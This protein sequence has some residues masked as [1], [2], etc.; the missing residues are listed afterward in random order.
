[1]IINP[2]KFY[3]KSVLF[4]YLVFLITSLS[5]RAADKIPGMNLY[6]TP[7][8]VVVKLMK[9]KKYKRLP[10]NIVQKIPV[11]EGFVTEI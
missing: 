5:A 10:Q 2:N 3:E 11:C 7:A 9:I 4:C 1:M 6:N 8:P